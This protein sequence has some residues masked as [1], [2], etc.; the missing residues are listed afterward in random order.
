MKQNCSAPSRRARASIGTKLG[1]LFGL[2]LLQI[3]LICQIHCTVPTRI[4]QTARPHLLCTFPEVS[5]GII[6]N[7][8][9]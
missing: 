8:K 4:M 2:Q 3:W 1:N 6:I 5:V 9:P 7:T